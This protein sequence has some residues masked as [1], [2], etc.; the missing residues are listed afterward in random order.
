MNAWLNAH[1]ISRGRFRRADIKC[2]MHTRACERYIFACFIYSFFLLCCNTLL[3]F[4]TFII[5]IITIADTHKKYFKIY[6]YLLPIF[7]LI[8]YVKLAFILFLLLSLIT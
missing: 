5:Y 8:L 6:Y 7:F 2:K 3:K 4:H 1:F